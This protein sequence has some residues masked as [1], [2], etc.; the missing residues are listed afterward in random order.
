MKNTQGRSQCFI[1]IT[2][3]LIIGFAGGVIVTV[4]KVPSIVSQVQ[5][6]QQ[7]QATEKEKNDHI[8]QLEEEVGKN[9]QDVQS[10]IHLGNAYFD[11]EI[12][13][14]AINAYLKALDLSPDNPD[15]LTDLGVMYRLNKQPQK[16]IEV[17]KKAALIDPAHIQSRFNIGVV[18]FHDLND[19]EGAVNASKEVAKLQPDYSLSTGQTILQLLESLEQ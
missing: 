4:Y 18:L 12:P 15:V 11:S 19:K 3:A 5:T 8:K 14:K 1:A 2:L 7:E 9:Q 13:E 6:P 16:A 17:F 10:W